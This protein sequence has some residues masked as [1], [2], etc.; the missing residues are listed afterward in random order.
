MSINIKDYLKRKRTSIENFIV[1]NKISEHQEIVR[2]CER[3]G[4]ESISEK[5]FMDIIKKLGLIPPKDTVIAKEVLE[6]KTAAPEKKRVRRK[7][8]SV[9]K[10]KVSELKTEVED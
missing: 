5:E 6:K 1:D 4:C 9:S 10:N 8:K 3:R 2:Y 7:S